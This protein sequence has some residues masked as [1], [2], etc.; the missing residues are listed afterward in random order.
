MEYYLVDNFSFK[1]DGKIYNMQGWST[2]NH[3]NDKGLTTTQ[4]EDENVDPPYG[5]D[6]KGIESRQFN[7][8]LYPKGVVYSE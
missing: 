2:D 3:P 5:Y 8:G 6:I 7:L 1:K 4:I